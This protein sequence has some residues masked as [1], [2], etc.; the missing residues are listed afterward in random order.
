MGRYDVALSALGDE[1]EGTH[2]YDKAS[3]QYALALDALTKALALRPD[4]T[5]LIRKQAVVQSR[6][7][8]LWY[9]RGDLEKALNELERAFDS[10]WKALQ[11]DYSGSTLNSNLKFYQDRLTRIRKAVTDKPATP[12]PQ[13]SLTPAASQALLHRIDDLATRTDASKLLDRNQKQ[14]TWGLPTIMPGVWRIL[15]AA[16]R[17]AP[18]QHLLAIDKNVTADQVQGIRRIP[19]DFYD[20]AALYEAEVKLPNDKD[21][22]VTFVQRGT[23][24]VLL[25][26]TATVEQMNKT[27]APKLDTPDRALSYLCF[28]VGTLV[29]ADHGRWR[30]IDRPGRY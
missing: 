16:E 25:E 8:D 21:G 19:L 17:A 15:T 26:S 28:W 6:I 20:D 12:S 30:L 7:S 13:M 4:D 9:D 27:S 11:Y 18:V 1:Y 10:V 14:A 29:E 5:E 24:W 3:A 2:E 22:I 23:E